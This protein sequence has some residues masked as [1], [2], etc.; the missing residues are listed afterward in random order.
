ME[1]IPYAARLNTKTDKTSCYVGIFR[2]GLS[3]N[4]QLSGHLL[5]V[6]CWQEQNYLA[7]SQGLGSNEHSG[8][9]L[10]SNRKWVSV[11]ELLRGNADRVL[12][13]QDPHTYLAPAFVVLWHCHFETYLRLFYALQGSQEGNSPVSEGWAGQGRQVKP[14]ATPCG[15]GSALSW[16]TCGRWA[17]EGAARGEGGS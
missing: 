17:V 15:P 12:V 7:F 16:G 3:R 9:I 14:E 13:P 2:A 4:G 5:Q 11:E 6:S 10:I 1:S 8:V